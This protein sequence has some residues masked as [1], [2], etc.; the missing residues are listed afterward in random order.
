MF[1][2][3]IEGNAFPLSQLSYQHPEK[4]KG[5]KSKREGSSKELHTLLTLGFGQSTK[6]GHRDGEFPFTQVTVCQGAVKGT[7]SRLYVLWGGNSLFA[8]NICS[9]LCCGFLTGIPPGSPLLHTA[10]IPPK[11]SEMHP[12]MS[13]TKESQSSRKLKHNKFYSQS[14]WLVRNITNAVGQSGGGFVLKPFFRHRHWRPLLK[15]WGWGPHIN[16]HWCLGA[17]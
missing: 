3:V 5:W 14:I 6:K 16:I 8:I 4:S 10:H 15:H 17:D 12:F 1:D 13:G 11:D 7:L 9:A 2:E